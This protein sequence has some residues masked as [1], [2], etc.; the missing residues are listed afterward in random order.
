MQMY[1]LKPL[2]ESRTQATLTSGEGEPSGP[3]STTL[4]PS[5]QQHMKQAIRDPLELC[6]QLGLPLS[7]VPDARDAASSF[8]L[9]APRPFVSRMQHGNPYDPLLRQLL[10]IRDELVETPGFTA[11]PLAEHASQGAHGL[12]QKYHGRA[13]LVTTG[14][15]AI[16]CRYCFRRHFP[17]HESS[18]AGGEWQPAIDQLAADESIEEVIL[19]GGD[20]LTLV[21]SQLEQLVDHLQEI[22]HLKQIRIHTRLPIMIP[23]RVCDSLLGWLTNTRL[24]PIMVIHANHAQELDG[25]VAEALGRLAEA[26]LLLLNQSVLLAGVNDNAT[27]LADLS[28]RLIELRVLPYYLHQLDRVRGAAHF[29]VSTERGCEIIEQLAAILPGYGVPRYVRESPGYAGKVPI[30]SSLA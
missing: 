9:F 6:Q 25:E 14:A 15:C 2:Q 29:E 12:L 27:T 3:H 1:H 8:P 17:Y 16:H 26:G 30:T 18:A 23:S 28:R 13:L 7:L 5:W 11:D 4:Q 24:Q 19:S 10:P 21:D 20:P 22:P